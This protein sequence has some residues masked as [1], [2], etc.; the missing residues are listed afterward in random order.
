M[1]GGM[2]WKLGES[3]DTPQGIQNKLPALTDTCGFKGLFS[4]SC[5]CVTIHKLAIDHNCRNSLLY[6]IK[7]TV[8]VAP[9]VSG[10]SSR[11]FN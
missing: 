5:S 1:P 7:V 11:Y 9:A 10:R 6:A 8:A 4:Q 2:L 3:S